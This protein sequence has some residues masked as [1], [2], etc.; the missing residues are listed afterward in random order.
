MPILRCATTN[1]GKLNEFRMA[2]VQF[3]FTAVEIQPLDEPKKIAPPEEEGE[4]FEENAIEKA[5]YYS[6]FCEEPLFADDSGLE[7]DTL[8]GEPGIRSARYAGPHSTDK[9]NNRLLLTRLRDKTDR[10][11]R[12]VCLIALAQQGKLLGTFRGVVEGRI[13]EEERGPRGFGYDPLFYYD[14]FGCTFGEVESARKMEVS[15]RGQ[16]LSQMLAAYATSL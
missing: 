1:P 5:L 3:G 6:V 16:A 15:H 2:A 9:E 12:F 11:A 7:V 8:H 4:S 10:R 13:V 14:P